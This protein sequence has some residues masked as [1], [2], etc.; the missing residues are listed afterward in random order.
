VIGIEDLNVSGMMKNR[1]LSRA[2]ADQSF[3]E[4]RRQM[5]YKSEWYGAELVIYPRFKPSSK[6]CCACG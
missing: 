6:M 2:I 4:F 5:A 3:G 1:H